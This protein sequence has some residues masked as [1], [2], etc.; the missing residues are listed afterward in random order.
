V[1]SFATVL[2]THAL[3]RHRRVK[4]ATSTATLRHPASLRPSLHI[5][6]QSFDRFDEILYLVEK[7]PD[8]T[9]ADSVRCDILS[10][11]ALDFR[12]ADELRSGVL[13]IQCPLRP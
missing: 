12:A 10:Q 7:A 2:L 11:F 3:A 8:L 1:A 6:V 13:L 9:L 5:H 4:G